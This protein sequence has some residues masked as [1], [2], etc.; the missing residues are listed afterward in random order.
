MTYTVI[1]N[2]VGE[3]S[4]E[5]APINKQDLLTSAPIMNKKMMLQNI[6]E[7]GK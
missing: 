7:M 4:K 6:Q 5:S 1:P 2:A 3:E